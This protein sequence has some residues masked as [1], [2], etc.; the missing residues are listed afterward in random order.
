MPAEQDL[1]MGHQ[2]SQ[3]YRM[4]MDPVQHRAPGTVGGGDGGVR[5]RPQARGRRAPAISVAVRAAV[6]DGA[7][8]LP[9]WCSST[10]SAESKNRRG[11]RWR[12]AS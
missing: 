1:L 10:T 8:A 9:A 3:A 5:G 4:H 6:P 2:A 12:T 11:L 7:S